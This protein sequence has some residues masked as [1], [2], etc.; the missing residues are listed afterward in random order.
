LSVR[1]VLTPFRLAF[2]ALA[3]LVF[4]FLLLWLVP[5]NSYIFLPDRAHPVDPLVRVQGGHKPRGGG[6]YFVDIFVRKAS[7]I[8]RLWPGIHEGAQLVPRSALLAPGVTDEQRVAA[9]QREMTRSQ[10]IAA[11]VALRAAGYRVRA[12]P[13]GALVEQVA[14]D[15]PAAGKLLPTDVIVAAAGKRVR[16]PLDLRRIVEKQRPGATIRIT[17]RRGTQLKQVSVRTIEDPRRPGRAI[18]GVFIQQAAF[19]KLP[20]KV[21]IDAGNVGGPSAGLA[22]ALDVLE[23]L[24]R[25]VDH[26]RR[27]AATGQIELDGTVTAVGGLE[28]K[29]IGVRRSGIHF[30]LVPAGENA[31][32]ARRYAH[33]VR[34][35]PV[36]SFRQALH[37]LATLTESTA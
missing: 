15:A 23:Q 7:L 27:I 14:S 34:I 13:T 11:A 22:F 16:T 17:V 2:A 19:I 35:V 4:T 18:I 20:L 37:L 36:H 26:G 28:Q 12:N 1:R 31:A 8:E 25:D 32:E 5:S 10:Q 21:Q 29:T 33:G 9:D 24:G 3:L 6:I 30:F